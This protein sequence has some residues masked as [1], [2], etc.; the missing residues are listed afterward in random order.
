MDISDKTDLVIPREARNL[1]VMASK[2][3]ILRPAASE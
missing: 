2:K 3:Q 1:L